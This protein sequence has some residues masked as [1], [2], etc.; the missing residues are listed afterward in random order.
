[1]QEPMTGCFEL[2]STPIGMKQMKHETAL[3]AG[4][5]C[6]ICLG[7]FGFNLSLGLGPQM[8]VTSHV[9]GDQAA[10]LNDCGLN[11][12]ANFHRISKRFSF[13][14][15]TPSCLGRLDVQCMLQTVVQTIA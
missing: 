1:M 3:C 11:P 12:R 10:A 15:P 9:L 14:H 2:A 8:A 5:E 6:N 7:S 13:G 4:L